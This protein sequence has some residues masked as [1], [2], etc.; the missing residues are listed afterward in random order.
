MVESISD[1]S[2]AN[3]LLSDGSNHLRNVNVGSLGTTLG[4]EQGRIPSAELFETNVTSRL[5]NTG[6]DTTYPVLHRLL[7]VAT[8]IA[9]QLSLLEILD[10]LVA[11][12]VGFFDNAVVPPSSV[13]MESMVDSFCSNGIVRSPGPSSTGKPHDYKRRRCSR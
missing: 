4:H 8:G 1:T 13:C 11:L 9:L 12:G 7:F 5:T 10:Q 3:H 2:T 6:Q